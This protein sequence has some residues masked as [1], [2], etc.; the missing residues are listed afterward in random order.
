M[1]RRSRRWCSGGDVLYRRARWMKPVTDQRTGVSGAL[2]SSA[3]TSSRYPEA[4]EPAHADVIGDKK[5]ADQCALHTVR[6]AED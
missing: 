6:T 5:P 3:S 2:R 4:N 1:R